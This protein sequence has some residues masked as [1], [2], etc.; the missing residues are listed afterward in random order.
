MELEDNFQPKSPGH[1]RLIPA[2]ILLVMIVFIF[3]IGLQLFRGGLTQPTSGMAP[4]F[5]M[6]TFNG[7]NFRLSDLRGQIVIVNFWASWCL[8]CREEAP[9]LQ[10]VWERYR[11]RGVTVVGI[12]YLDT[13]TE[14]LA[15]LGEFNITYPNGQDLRTEISNVYRIRGVPETF[16]IDRD[17]NIV[18]F[19]IAPVREGQ[20]D[21]IIERLR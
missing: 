6:T 4:D 20:L 3:I 17:G 19:I 12:A 10:S 2:L 21:I 1:L 5:A 11:E 15:F 7:E 9:I 16:V 8:P 14:A 13:E 18:E